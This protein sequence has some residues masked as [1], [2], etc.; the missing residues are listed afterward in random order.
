[1][2]DLKEA[3]VKRAVEDYL[4]LLRN[5]KKLWFT[6][7]NSGNAFKEFGGRRYRIKLCDEGTADY[8]VI[9][10]DDFLYEETTEAIFL[11][12]KS[13]KGKQSGKQKEF[14]AEVEEQGCS[15]FVVRSLE[16]VEGLLE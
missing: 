9:T 4:Q 11:E 1:M 15:Y 7:L 12:I 8:L 2:T 10:M 14:Q 13:A 5:Q 3:D 16:E 6:R